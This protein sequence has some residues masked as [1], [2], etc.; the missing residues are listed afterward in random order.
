MAYKVF[1]VE[2]EVVTREGI[3]DSVRWKDQGFE[4]CGEASDGETA[5]AQLR[6]LHPDVLFT[7]IRMPFMD[8]LQLGKIIREQMPWMKIVIL[9]GH[10][11]FEYAQE[12]INLGVA[13]YLLKPITVQDMHNTLQKLAAQLDQER[14]QQENLKKLLEQKEEINAM[15]KEKLLLKVITGAV[16][17]TEAI[18]QGQALGL[19][20]IAKC[21]L[22]MILSIDSKDVS[23]QLAYPEYQ[24]GESIV[25]GVVGVHPDVFL[26]KKNWNELVLLIK[27]DHPNHLDEESSRV[28]ESVQKEI[29][30]TRYRI[31]VGRG[32][33]KGR[34]ADIYL[35]FIDAF[36]DLQ[37]GATNG[38]REQNQAVEKAELLKVNKSAVEAYLNCGVK[39]DLDE[40]FNVY[41][42]PLSETALRSYL[43][44]NY[45]FVDIILAVAKM[46]DKLGGKIDPLIPELNSLET[47]LS[48]IKT[49]EQLK[50][51]ILKLLINAMQFRDSQTGSLHVRQI[52]QAKDFIE[53]HFM[54][55]DLSLYEVASLVNLSPSYFSMIFSQETSQTFKE[56]LTATRINK[57]RELLRTTH[58]SLNEISGQAGFND[59]HYFSHIFKKNSGMSPTEFRSMNQA[60]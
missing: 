12:A 19:D 18:E 20:L 22:V 2:D 56:Y 44:K 36:I 55:P 52:R 30:P 46:V 7:D 32:S 8:G 27:A 38:K 1:L 23:R 6:A 28:I 47:L 17:S 49:G 5:L 21:F 48:A 41:I 57:A 58:L 26:L 35:S 54:D 43:I 25:T 29:D 16:N 50:A 9:S 40:F 42:Q 37:N 39:E 11:E 45:L 14:K 10:D 33:Q 53:L 13:E 24:Q 31:L 4:F 3:R 15:L 59:A 60:Q 51:E 34:I